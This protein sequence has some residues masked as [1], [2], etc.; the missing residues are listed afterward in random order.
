M[1]RDLEEAHQESFPKMHTSLEGWVGHADELDD[2]DEI[3]EGLSRRSFLTR[4]G[5]L[6]AGGLLVS[7]GGV[8][9]ASTF[10]GRG[11]SSVSQRLI[12][13]LTSVPLDVRVAALAASLENLAVSTYSSALAAA[14]AGKLGTVPSAVATFVETAMT[15]HRDHSAAWNAVIS[16]AGY[17]PITA[18]NAP[19]G[20]VVA[21]AFAK[22][23]NVAGVASLAL[24]LEEIA[25]ATYLEAIG[26]VSAHQ[27]IETAATI[28][29]V[30]MQHIAILNFV[31]SR[32]P[33]PEAFA[34]MKGAATLSDGPSIGHR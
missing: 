20:K 26:V 6:A 21:S 8:A 5:L 27:A 33:A 1:T 29:P 18:P 22:V 13:P 10:T 2:L 30:E 12:A 24:T 34:S 23:T 17:R 31:L 9:G 28:Q 7:A 32:Y 19:L 14:T 4:T 11:G 3:D 15:Q 25:A 16:S